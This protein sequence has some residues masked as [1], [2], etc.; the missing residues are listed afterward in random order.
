M[1]NQAIIDSLQ[2]AVAALPR[3]DVWVSPGRRIVL[4]QKTGYSKAHQAAR[5]AAPQNIAQTE[6]ALSKNKWIAGLVTTLQLDG[7]TFDM[8]REN[9]ERWTHP[10]DYLRMT[11]AGL[12]LITWLT[13]TADRPANT[14]IRFLTNSYN[15]RPLP[16]NQD[17]RIDSNPVHAWAALREPIINRIVSREGFAGLLQKQE[18]IL[19]RLGAIWDYTMSRKYEQQERVTEFNTRLTHHVQSILE[20]TPYPQFHTGYLPEIFFRYE[21]LL[22]FCSSYGEKTGVGALL[23]AKKPSLKLFRLVISKALHA[24]S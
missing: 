9:S 21:I 19:V 13:E 2:T 24:N 15:E 10:M 1:S 17:I 20:N 6:L 22:Y 7:E 16:P 3:T 23:E 5:R 8:I 11:G 4:N 14:V 18:R 12:D